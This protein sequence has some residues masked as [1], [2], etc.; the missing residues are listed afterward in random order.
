MKLICPE[1]KNAVDCTPYPTI[2][3]G[4]VVECNWCGVTLQVSALNG[5]EVSAEIIDEGK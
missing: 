4:S 5:D 3:A 2:A 1:C